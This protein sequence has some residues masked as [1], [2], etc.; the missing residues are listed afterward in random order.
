MIYVKNEV[1]FLANIGALDKQVDKTNYKTLVLKLFAYNYMQSHI[2][3][4]DPYLI[5]P[6]TRILGRIAAVLPESTGIL[7]NHYQVG[8][9]SMLTLSAV[10]L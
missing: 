3:Y 9:T 4:L 2:Q 7:G 1:I 10:A 5:S 8:S 6:N